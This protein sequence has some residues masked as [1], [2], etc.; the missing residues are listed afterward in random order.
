MEESIH[1]RTTFSICFAALTTSI[2]FSDYRGLKKQIT[3]IR[4]IQ[5]EPRL[6]QSTKEVQE[7]LSCKRF[8][9]GLR[10]Q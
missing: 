2:L 3:L 6:D 4:K 7:D 8:R 10:F 5:Q 9:Y 1:V